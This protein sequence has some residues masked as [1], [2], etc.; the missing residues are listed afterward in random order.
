MTSSIA[1]WRLFDFD[2]DVVSR[3]AKD[4][5]R[6]RTGEAVDEDV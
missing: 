5:D 4:A 3:H 2:D 6:D 1:C